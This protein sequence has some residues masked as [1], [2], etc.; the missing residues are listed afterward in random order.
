MNDQ[1]LNTPIE[2]EDKKGAVCLSL[3]AIMFILGALDCALAW[4]GS[5][6]VSSFYV[7]FLA[8]G[9]SLYCVGMVRAAGDS[10]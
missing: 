4:R 5:F 10:D 9:V 1:H 7:A 3:G 8:G 6:E 2:G